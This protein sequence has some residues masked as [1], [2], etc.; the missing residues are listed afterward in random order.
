[1]GFIMAKPNIEKRNKKY[2]PVPPSIKAPAI[3]KCVIRRVLNNIAAISCLDFRTN[4]YKEAI[5]TISIII[6]ISNGVEPS[7]M[8]KGM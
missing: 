2:F 4:K 5:E 3:I 7:L 6:C 8:N 1:M